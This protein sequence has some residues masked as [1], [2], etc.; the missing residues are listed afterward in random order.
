M[1]YKRSSRA[2]N[3]RGSWARM[4]RRPVTARAATSTTATW[5]ALDS[6]T[7]AFAL[8]AK[9]MPTGS[10]KRVDSV[11]ASTSSMVAI[12]WW[13]EGLAGSASMTLTV[14]ET[15]LAT[16]TSRP[17]GRGATL[18]GSTPTLMRA[19]TARLSG[20]MTSTVSAGVFA[21]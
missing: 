6:A 20:S 7:Y 5:L 8:F 10:S 13:N 1:T 19:T 17:S 12:T 18:T 4:G 15:W 3:A 21:T 11:S 9:A 16:H 2:T 14:S